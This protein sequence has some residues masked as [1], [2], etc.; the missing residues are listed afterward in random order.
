MEHS[1]AIYKT[2]MRKQNKQK[3]FSKLGEDECFF[4]LIKIINEK[5]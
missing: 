4:N 5:I 2:K 3:S 1:S